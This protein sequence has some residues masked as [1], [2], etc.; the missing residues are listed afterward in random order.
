MSLLSVTVTPE[1]TGKV[2]FVH[3]TTMA[4]RCLL[5][6]SQFMPSEVISEF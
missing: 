5:E 4:L 1:V 3:M 6:I 2:S